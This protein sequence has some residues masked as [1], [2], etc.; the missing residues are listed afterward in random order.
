MALGTSW[1][2]TSENKYKDV[3][4]YSQLY[5]IFTVNNKTAMA[6]KLFHL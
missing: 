5:L 3:P 6:K 4:T 1:N 2:N